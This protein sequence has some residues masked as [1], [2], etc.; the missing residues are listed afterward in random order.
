MRNTYQI[1][2]IN[3]STTDQIYKQFKNTELKKYD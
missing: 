3:I 2:N 1:G